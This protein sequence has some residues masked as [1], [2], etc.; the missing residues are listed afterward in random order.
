MMLDDLGLVDTKA[1]NAA[2]EKMVQLLK[3]AEA[4][5]DTNMNAEEAIV[6]CAG[7]AESGN[8]EAREL[9]HLIEEALKDP[10]F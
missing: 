5:S 9:K 4:L 8:A 10:F 7:L 6:F 2:A 3:R 1:D